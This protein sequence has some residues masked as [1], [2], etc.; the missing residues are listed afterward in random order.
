MLK[1]VREVGG[2]KFVEGFVSQEEYFVF[3]ALFDRE[4]VKL[5]EDGG[6]VL[7]GL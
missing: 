2:S 6:D 4:P 3:N 7:P 1:K 5:T